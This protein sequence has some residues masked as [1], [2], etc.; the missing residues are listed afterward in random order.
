[1]G[2]SLIVSEFAEFTDGGDE[3]A[4]TDDFGYGSGEFGRISG[5]NSCRCPLHNHL[6]FLS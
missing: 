4:G 6:T 2:A 1:M 3:C 5:N